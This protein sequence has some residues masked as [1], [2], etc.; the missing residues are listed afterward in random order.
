MRVRVP[1]E[2]NVFLWLFL[3]ATGA[4]RLQARV[5]ALGLWLH[6][7]SPETEAWRVLAEHRGRLL[8][9]LHPQSP[10]LADP[11]SVIDLGLQR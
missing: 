4:M 6:A 3:V 5:A 11:A 8:R 10:W 7:L 9:Q 1:R 2:H